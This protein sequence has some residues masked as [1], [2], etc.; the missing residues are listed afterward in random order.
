[1]IYWSL[2]LTPG[3]HLKHIEIVFQHLLKTRL[4]LKEIEC[5]FLKG[6]IQCLGHLVSETGIEPLPERWTVFRICPF[7]GI[8]KRLS[9]FMV[10]PIVIE[11]CYQDLLIFWDLWLP[12][13]RRTFHV[14][15]HGCVRTHSTYSI[16]TCFRVLFLN[17]LTLEGHVY[18]LQM[19]VCMLGHVFNAGIWSH[20]RR[21]RKDNLNE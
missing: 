19:L 2:G 14:N 17:A 16:N 11:N 4:R 12:L 18:C 7:L 5:N 20:C 9:N 8:Q 6:H 3:A 1:M 10:W 13:W 15:A 21:K